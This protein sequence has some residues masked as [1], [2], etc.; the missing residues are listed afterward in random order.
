MCIADDIDNAAADD[1]GADH[2]DS[3][4]HHHTATNDNFCYWMLSSRFFWKKTTVQ[5]SGWL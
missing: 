4:A 3:C 5:P 1:T 2:D